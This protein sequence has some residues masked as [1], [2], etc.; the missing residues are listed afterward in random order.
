MNF[1]FFWFPRKLYSPRFSVTFWDSHLF[2]CKCLVYL[3]GIHICSSIGFS[4]AFSGIKSSSSVL[5][6]PL[7]WDCVKSVRVFWQQ[8]VS[9]WGTHELLNCGE[10]RRYW[11]ISCWHFS[12]GWGGYSRVKITLSLTQGYFLRLFSK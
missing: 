8:F 7:S 11:G 9:P 3:L 2:F 4:R 1:L 10:G 6:C 12:L 5:L